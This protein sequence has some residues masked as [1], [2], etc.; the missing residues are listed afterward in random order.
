MGFKTAADWANAAA[1]SSCDVKVS[2]FEFDTS[3]SSCDV[4]VSHLAFDT[5]AGTCD[6]K[7][8]WL[9]FNSDTFP[10]NVR[11]SWLQFNGDAKQPGIRWAEGTATI[12]LGAVSTS[13]TLVVYVEIGYSI[14]GHGAASWKAFSNPQ[15]PANGWQVVKVLTV[16][17][18]VFCC[19]DQRSEVLT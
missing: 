2:W 6:V 9:A 13:F 1:A 12:L 17:N 11:V 3:A 15:C 18:Q 14:A 19:A 16:G 4:K 10:Y 8:S 5:Q 7:V